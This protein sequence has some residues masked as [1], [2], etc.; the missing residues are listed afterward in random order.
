[1]IECIANKNIQTADELCEAVQDCKR[2]IRGTKVGKNHKI[3]GAGGKAI[4]LVSKSDKEFIAY[5][6]V[7][8]KNGHFGKLLYKVFFEEETEEDASFDVDDVYL[9]LAEKLTTEQLTELADKLLSQVPRL[10]FSNCF[11]KA[12][13]YEMEIMDAKKWYVEI[14]NEDIIRAFGILEAVN[15]SFN[16]EKDAWKIVP[17]GRVATVMSQKEIQIQFLTPK[18]TLDDLKMGEISQ[19]FILIRNKYGEAFLKR[20]INDRVLL[21]VVC[22]D[23]RSIKDW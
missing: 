19:D 14:C 12:P 22:E 21:V 16:S 6:N 18:E 1:M 13:D 3:M 4:L 5:E 15:V 17:Y 7:M 10:D 20:D 11:T 8:A 2:E 9:D 23:T